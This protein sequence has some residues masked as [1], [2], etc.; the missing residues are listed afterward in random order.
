MAWNYSYIFSWFHRP[1]TWAKLSWAVLLTLSGCSHLLAGWGLGGLKWPCSHS[2][3]LELAVDYTTFF[4]RLA[5]ASAYDM[6]VLMYFSSPAKVPLTKANVTTPRV[7]VEG[8]TQGVPY[9]FCNNILQ[10][11]WYFIDWKLPECLLWVRYCASLSLFVYIYEKEEG[12]W[13]I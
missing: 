6:Q 4:S 13:I 3:W 11:R 2:W 12:C 1:T 9:H 7:N 5:Q 8:A 10:I